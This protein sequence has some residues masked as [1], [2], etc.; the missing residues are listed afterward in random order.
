MD[1]SVFFIFLQFLLYFVMSLFV[2]QWNAKG[3]RSHVGELKAYLMGCALLPHVICLQETNVPVNKTIKLPSYQPPVRLDRPQQAGGG[4][5][6]YVLKG[7]NFV[8]NPVPLNIECVSVKLYLQNNCFNVTSFYQPG[9]DINAIQKTKELFTLP[10][11]VMC[12]DFNAHSPLW[13]HYGIAHRKEGEIL[14]EYLDQHEYVCLNDGSTTYIGTLGQETAL[15][16]TFVSS[17]LA[18]CSSWKVHDDTLSSDHFPVL[19]NINFQGTPQESEDTI[20]VSPLNRWNTRKAIWYNFKEELNTSILFLDNSE[21]PVELYDSFVKCVQDTADNHIPFI[22]SKNPQI[23]Y[24]KKMAPWWNNECYSSMRAKKHALNKY[25]AHKTVTNYLKYKRLRAICNAVLRKAKRLSWRTLCHEFNRRSNLG[26]VW[27]I[28]K[29]MDGR[30]ISDRPSIPPIVHSGHTY[31]SDYNKANIIGETFQQTS[32][33]Q[34]F[35][36]SFTLH[37]SFFET[38]PKCPSNPHFEHVDTHLSINEPLTLIELKAA[39]ASTK[40]TSPGQDGI[41]YKMLKQLDDCSLNRLLRIYN[42]IWQSGKLPPSWNHSIVKPIHKP[43]KTPNAAISYRPISLTS[44]LCKLMEKIITPRLTWFLESNSLLN[45]QQSGFR[46]GRCTSDHIARIY[47]AANHSLHSQELTKAIFI[48]I[49]KAFDMVWHDGLLTKLYDMGINGH[50]FNWISNFLSNRTFQVCVG[51]ALSETFHLENGTPQGSVISPILFAIMINDIPFRQNIQYSLFAD[52]LAIWDSGPDEKAINKNLQDNLNILIHWCEEWGFKISPSKTQGIVFTKKRKLLSDKLTL[53]LEP[54]IFTNKIK[55]L[56]VTFDRLLTFNAHVQDVVNKCNRRFNIIKCL[57]GTTWGTGKHS[58]LIVYRGLIRSILE[59]SCFIYANVS[60]S[61]FHKLELI[62]NKCL[63]LICG[64][65]RST[66]IPA[67]HVELGELPLPLRFKFLNITYAIKCINAQ[68]HPSKSVFDIPLHTIYPTTSLSEIYQEYVDRFDTSVAG[69]YV[70]P[71]PPWHLPKLNIDVNLKNEVAK[72]IPGY[73]VKSTAL[74]YISRWTVYLAIYTDGSKM[75]DRVGCAYYIPQY[76]IKASFRLNNYLDVFTS[77][78]Y[79]IYKALLWVIDVKP[80]LAVI[81]SDSLSSLL[82]L[83]H[84]HPSNYNHLMLDIMLCYKEIINL[85]LDVWL[86]WVPAH[87]GLSGN[88]AA[89]TLAKASLDFPLPTCLIPLTISQFKPVLLNYILQIWQSYWETIE[90]ATFYRDL[91]PEV[92]LSIKYEDS[93]RS[94]ETAITRLR[95]SHSHLN[96]DRYRTGCHDTPL[97][98]I[99]QDDETV[100]HYLFE[101]LNYMDFQI[102]CFRAFQER[103][104]P[105]TLGNLLGGHRLGTIISYEYILATGRF[106]YL[107]SV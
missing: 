107:P 22:K 38:N 83:K 33:S 46:Q 21:N 53:D 79:A 62:Q 36:D 93:N 52:D 61:T 68:S 26:R 50:M 99:C 81:F 64:A 78:L 42:A 102:N 6:I 19:T 39:L 34:N 87:V 97:C 2:F 32:S 23:R 106:S 56:G 105:Y 59:Y 4:V 15:D 14:E 101:C 18:S 31:V 13:G 63:R 66:P 88:E 47:T 103:S 85:G 74:N 96:A 7:L 5:A 51:S 77:E 84:F 75:G 1:T 41:T 91:V 12:G 58:L 10:G 49:Q 57:A 43:G 37:K 65:Y 29:S 27:N 69:L 94:R 98:T 95:F 90:L 89:D 28:I 72:D 48:D 71:Q 25:R 92:S 82:A 16:L 20:P 3:V 104:I 54:I 11:H 80:T 45:L 30:A 24:K 100:Q 44:C 40:N 73:I 76:K 86:V 55:Y 60:R 9:G 17:N 8:E 67:L 70:P 35:T